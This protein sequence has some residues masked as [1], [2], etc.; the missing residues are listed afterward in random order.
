MRQIVRRTAL[1][2]FSLALL[3]GAAVTM[4]AAIAAKGT[5][6]IQTGNCSAASDW[7]LKVKPDNGAI[8]VEFEVDQN[9]VGKTWNVTLKHNGNVFWSGQKVT[10]APSGSFTVHKMTGNAAGTDT[11]TARAT[12]RVTGEVCLGSASL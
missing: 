3:A 12:N 5:A 8:E 6:V 1:S 11:F 9:R 4:P 2:A 7:K 10:K